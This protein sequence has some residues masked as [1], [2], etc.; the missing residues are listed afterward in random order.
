MKVTLKELND[1]RISLDKLCSQDHLTGKMK[2]RLKFLVKELKEIE[3]SKR[4]LMEKHKAKTMNGGYYFP[5]D[6]TKEYRAYSKELKD[7]L[8]EEIEVRYIP[9]KLSEIEAIKGDDKKPLI[10]L[11]AY[12][13]EVLC[14]TFV[15]DDV[16]NEEE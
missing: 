6:M 7:V 4:D 8:N 11:N 14:D 12:D 2:Y 3:E 13:Y 1:A 16:N 5:E 9:I 10:M 15:E